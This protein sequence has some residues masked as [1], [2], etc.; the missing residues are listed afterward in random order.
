MGLHILIPAAGLP[1]RQHMEAGDGGTCTGDKPMGLSPPSPRGRNPSCMGVGSKDS[2][3]ADFPKKNSGLAP[4]GLSI[5]AGTGAGH[6]PLWCPTMALKS[7]YL[8]DPGG[9][10]GASFPVPTRL[11]SGKCGSICEGRGRLRM[12]STA[13]DPVFSTPRKEV[14]GRPD[15]FLHGVL[16]LSA[17]IKR[18]PNE[19]GY[20]C[21]AISFFVPGGKVGKN[22]AGVPRTPDGQPVF[23]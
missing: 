4:E 18:C 11:A 22:A 8:G 10:L 2:V 14:A 9:P 17:H 19:K 12:I 7:K 5:L 1:S 23:F 16:G 21:A 20:Q 13:F 15:P 6:R 3:P